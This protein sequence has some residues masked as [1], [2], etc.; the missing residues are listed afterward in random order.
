MSPAT[1]QHKTDM[2]AAR[3][4]CGIA[5]ILCVVMTAVIVTQ[6]DVSTPWLQILACSPVVPA[7]A[8]FA[9]AASKR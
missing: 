4:L 5:I 1:I 3:Q 7:F 2:S 6:M 8:Y 9:Y